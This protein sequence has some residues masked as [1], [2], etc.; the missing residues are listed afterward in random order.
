[1]SKVTLDCTAIATVDSILALKKFQ[2]KQLK[3]EDF[4]SHSK[5][6]KKN[7]NFLLKIEHAWA[8][9]IFMIW[10]HYHSINL[11]YSKVNPKS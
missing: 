1:M 2:M 11:I 7:S 5:M 4:C 10:S 6:F 9:W 3:S 8:K